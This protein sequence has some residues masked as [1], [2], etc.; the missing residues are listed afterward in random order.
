MKY[1]V[2]YFIGFLSLG[3]MLGYFIFGSDV[4]AVPVAEIQDQHGKWTCSM[5]P[6]VD[7]KEGAKCPLCAMDLVFMDAQDTGGLKPNQF[8]MT[9]DAVA[10]ANISTTK[11]AHGSVEDGTLRLTGEIKM[12]RETEAIQTIIFDGRINTLYPDAVGKKVRKGQKI[13]L[14]YSPELYSAQDRFLTT[15]SYQGTI[16]EKLYQTARNTLGLWKVT[17]AQI[18]EILKLGKPMSNF[19][20]YADVSGT[21]VEVF[22]SEGKYYKE[23]EPLFKTADLRT[24]WAVF[25]AFE[26]QLP[27]LKVGQDVAIGLK[28]IKGAPISGKIALIEPMVDQ[29]SRTVAVRVVLDNS[30]GKLLPGMFATATVSLEKMEDI[31]TIP[32]SAAL[33]TGKR[34]VVYK[35]IDGDKPIFE[36]QEVLL[37]K[38]VNN[39]YEV[40][41]G[42]YPDDIIVT[43]G[44]FTIDAAAQLQGK[45][46]MMSMPSET[47]SPETKDGV[48][49]ENPS[50]NLEVKAVTDFSTITHSYMAIKDALV[51]SDASKTQSLAAEMLRHIAQ[52]EVDINTSAQL[53]TILAKLE[54]TH[55]LELQ[56][57]RFKELSDLF[58]QLNSKKALVN[59]TIYRQHC[60]CVNGGGASWLSYQKEVRNPYFGDVMLTCGRV[61]EVF[62]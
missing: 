1:K 3:L 31:I 48:L 15:A 21:V 38:K 34:S 49:E 50:I 28:G 44:A 4:K 40:V 30:D 8:V 36:M 25:D 51:A 13:G 10:L 17:D 62:K 47:D 12:N 11:V 29:V 59:E 55:T 18:E 20:L 6:S 42:L 23:G 7:G 37:G 9:E 33:W 39:R 41:Q 2:L 58:I 56:R 35:K 26:H 54:T 27:F 60:D 19:P 53:R 57:N 22:A 5:H 45:R 52:E 32:A 43:E 16:N 46:T 61:E 14:V 24:V